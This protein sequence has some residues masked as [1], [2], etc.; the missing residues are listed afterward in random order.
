MIRLILIDVDGTLVGRNGVHPATWEALEQAR[1]RGVHLGLCTGRPGCGRALAHARRVA[2]AGLHI[3]HGGAVVSLPGQP[4]AYCSMLPRDA[5]HALVAVSRR[6]GQPLEAYTER[7]YF[8]EWETA[9]IRVHARHLEMEPEVCDLLEIATPVVR[10]QWV[11]DEQDWPHFRALTALAGEIEIQPATAP[12]S[13]GTVFANLTRVGASKSS[14]L[15]WLAGHYGLEVSEVA[16]IGDAENDLDAMEAAGLGIAMGNA[17]AAVKE[18][19]RLVVG[20]VDA[21]GLAEAIG[22]ALAW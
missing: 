8:L 5:F 10:A 21:G 9:L 19:A 17:S 4:A 16:M 1:Q 2:P 18:R 3:F 22:R 15:R 14:A 12:W 13:P 7:G 6:E 11:V 20:D